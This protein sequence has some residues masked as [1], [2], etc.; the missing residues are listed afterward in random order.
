[1]RVGLPLVKD[2]LTSFPKSLLIPLELKATASAK[3]AAKK[4][5]TDEMKDI[6]N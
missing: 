2:L 6:I 5:F 1:M 3:D 4:K